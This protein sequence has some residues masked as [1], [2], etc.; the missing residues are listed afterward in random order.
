MV[1]VLKKEENVL[2]IPFERYMSVE[3]QKDDTRSC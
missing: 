1:N 3:G 2:T